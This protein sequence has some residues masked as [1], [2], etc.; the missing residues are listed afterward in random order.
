MTET[1]I[2]EAP[3]RERIAELNAGR[4]R[5]ELERLHGR[6]WDPREL[7]ADFEVMGFMAPLVVARRRTDGKVGSLEFQH[8]PRLYFNWR[9]DRE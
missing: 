4:G 7:A 8:D 3:R 2:T 5:R 6:T 1:D 9:E